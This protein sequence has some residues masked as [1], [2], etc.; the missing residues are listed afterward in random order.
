MLSMLPTSSSM[1]GLLTWCGCIW[2]PASPNHPSFANPP[3]P[4]LKETLVNGND[5]IQLGYPRGPIIG[6]AL[7]VAY[8][9]LSE[10]PHYATD[11]EAAA[12]RATRAQLA[13][14]LRNHDNLPAD[15]PQDVLELAQALN[16]HHAALKETAALELMPEATPFS[17]AG[18]ELIDENTLEQMRAAMRLPI[19]VAGFLAPDAHYGYGL[20]VGGVW[21]TGASEGGESGLFVAPYAVGVDVGCR[22][23]VSVYNVSPDAVDLKD[24]RQAVHKHTI[25]GAG[26]AFQ[27]RNRNDDPI[28]ESPEWR[29]HPWLR[30]NPNLRDTA[31][32]QLGTSGGGNHFINAGVI[33]YPDGTER[34]GIMTHSGSRGL[35]AKIANHY[36]KL[37]QEIRK[38]LDKSVRHLAWL[39]LDKQE[40]QEYWRAMQLA[41]AY[42]AANHDA[43]HRRITTHLDLPVAD[44]ISN[45]HNF[46]WIEDV[47]TPTGETV[48]SVVHRKGAT[49]AGEGVRG[50]IPGS[51]G[52]P[53][54]IVKGK[55]NPTSLNSASHGSGR[56]M[57]RTQAKQAL[58]G[59]NL[60]K[61]MLERGVEL[62]GG[63][64][65]EAPEVYKPINEVMRY[66]EHLVEAIAEFHPF[67]VRMAND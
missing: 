64:L 8:R 45:F 12:K 47:F 28:M 3:V 39:D 55:G 11:Q 52:T 17:I 9:L 66:Q 50:V 19:T 18:A 35:G 27:G 44:T 10:H 61:E 30:K 58:A 48:K 23:Q 21:A 14:I 62:I 60:K 4:S 36:S 37:A 15:T 53:A 25:F 49:P 29:E 1:V 67:L 20:P 31:A 41:G 42:A 5:I 46:A 32:V 57:S 63:A 22:M 24:I 40:G 16:D 6:K 33:K 26:G 38:G 59:R 34:L 65:D 51:M 2:R 43:I 7:A 56:V 54:M 13:D